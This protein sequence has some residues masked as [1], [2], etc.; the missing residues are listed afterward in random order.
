MLHDEGLTWNPIKS[1]PVFSY[2]FLVL[3]LFAYCLVFLHVRVI[4]SS[5]KCLKT[6][7][8]KK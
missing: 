8:L 1:F 7:T 6:D 4:F 2:V 3:E 5:P